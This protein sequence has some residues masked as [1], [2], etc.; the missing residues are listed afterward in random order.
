MITNL[1][2]DPK[3]TKLISSYALEYSRSKVLVL[4]ERRKHLEDIRDEILSQDPHAQIGLYR[5]QM[6]PED[7]KHSESKAIILGTYS[8][9]SVGLDIKGLNTLILA[10]PRSDV[11]QASGRIQRDLSPLFDKLIIDVYDK[12]SVFSGQYAKRLQYYRQ[13]EFDLGPVNK[14][15]RPNTTENT[16]SPPPS[17]LR[18]DTTWG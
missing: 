12:F 13:S 17:S 15:A 18:I 4:S 3:R 2:A 5:G 8:I 16:P 11:V 10:T 6:K 9:A 1:V 7:L 14:R